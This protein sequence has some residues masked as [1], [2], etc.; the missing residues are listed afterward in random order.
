LVLHY[1]EQSVC[2][3]FNELLPKQGFKL[4]MRLQLQIHKNPWYCKKKKKCDCCNHNYNHDVVA[5]TTKTFMLL[6]QLQLQ[7]AT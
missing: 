4:L 6:S 2:Q 7:T 3:D 5:V 1:L